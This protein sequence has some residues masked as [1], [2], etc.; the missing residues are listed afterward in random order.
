V[1]VGF[2]DAFFNINTVKAIAQANAGGFAPPAT[3]MT[4][5]TG[6]TSRTSPPNKVLGLPAGRTA[7]RRLDLRGLVRE[8]TGRGYR[9]STIKH[10][11]SWRRH[12]P[13]PPMLQGKD[14][15]INREAPR[16]HEVIVHPANDG[17]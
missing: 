13:P 5:A 15:Y 9:I 3:I 10:A 14:S 7:A 17:S 8:W 6:G 2:L 4:P 11:H 1:G 16:G 12:P